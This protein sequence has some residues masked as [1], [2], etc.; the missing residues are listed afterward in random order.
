MVCCL[1]MLL[2]EAMVVMA[3]MEGETMEEVMMVVE[4]TSKHIL[5]GSRGLKLEVR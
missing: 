3:E 2:M 5:S 4:E 1:S